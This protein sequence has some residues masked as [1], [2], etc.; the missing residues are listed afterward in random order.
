MSVKSLRMSQDDYVDGI[1]G[2]EKENK[3]NSILK[4]LDSVSN[5]LTSGFSKALMSCMCQNPPKHLL[6]DLHKPFRK[7][8]ASAQKQSL[9]QIA[10]RVSVVFKQSC[11]VHVF[12][13]DTQPTDLYKVVRKPSHIRRKS[14]SDTLGPPPKSLDLKRSS[15]TQ[16]LTP[17]S[18][19][20]SGIRRESVTEEVQLTSK[21]P[22]SS[23][24]L[25]AHN[26]HLAPPHTL[27]FMQQAIR[28]RNVPMEGTLQDLPEE[29][30]II[31]TWTA[32]RGG[33]HTDE[34]RTDRFSVRTDDFDAHTVDLALKQNGYLPRIMCDEF[35]MELEL[36]STFFQDLYKLDTKLKVNGICPYLTQLDLLTDELKNVYISDSMK[37][38]IRDIAIAIRQHS[39][40]GCGPSPR[41]MKSFVWSVKMH[42]L[43]CGSSFVR[44]FDVDSTAVDA[45]SHRFTL[46]TS[47][48]PFSPTAKRRAVLKELI[49]KIMVP[50]R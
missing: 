8:D 34:Y 13:A 45:L 23:S 39:L 41:A 24:I 18:S 47:F 25:I 11:A 3:L 30:I 35:F 33:S 36:P 19:R 44:P 46:K 14:Y 21:G 20:G 29:Q 49:F 38:Y 9:I 17:Q 7:V 43:W 5:V 50:P 27:A 40:V 37:Q 32:E 22:L 28:M 2:E 4:S 10:Q 12:S 48:D 1:N 31:A 16:P 6:L 42:A 15:T 26:M